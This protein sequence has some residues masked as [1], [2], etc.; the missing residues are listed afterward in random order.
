MDVD[1]LKQGPLKVV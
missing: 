1:K